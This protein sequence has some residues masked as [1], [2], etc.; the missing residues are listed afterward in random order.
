MA[1]GETHS[2]SLTDAMPSIVADCRLKKEFAGTWRRTCDIKRQQEGTGLN[3]TEFTLNQLERQSITE[4]QD[5]RNFQQLS[6]TLQSIEPTMNQIIVKITDRT[7][8]KLAKV[9]SRDRK[10]TR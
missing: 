10:S 9:V 1:T 2:G 7:Y 8:R 5:N 6:G 4:T 3:W